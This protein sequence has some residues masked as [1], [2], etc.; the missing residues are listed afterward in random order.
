MKSRCL[1]T[2]AACA[3]GLWSASTASAVP[4]LQIFVDTPAAFNARVSDG[5]IVAGINNFPPLIGGVNWGLNVSVR[6]FGAAGND[7][8][9][10]LGT[11]QHLIP[12]HGEGMGPQFGFFM[13]FGSFGKPNGFHGF[14]E[15]G[16]VA[17]PHGPHWDNFRAFGT[18]E[19]FAGQIVSWHVDIRAEHS[20]TP[21]PTPATAVLGTL[22]PLA[23]A[24]RRR[25]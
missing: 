8:L 25:R 20:D 9:D 7:S 3:A 17:K 5:A 2:V 4:I 12:P 11:L 24:R 10:V 18:A 1:L 16:W 15:T 22:A 14:G 6:T 19:V 13:A 23:I 21:M